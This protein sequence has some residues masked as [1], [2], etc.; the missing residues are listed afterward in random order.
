VCVA[1]YL[2]NAISVALISGEKAV[3]AMRLNGMFKQFYVNEGKNIY[4]FP[5]I[6]V[7]QKV[8]NNRRVGD[9]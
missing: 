6:S 2:S 1:K 4:S 8:R 7:V 5:R 9:K 3:R